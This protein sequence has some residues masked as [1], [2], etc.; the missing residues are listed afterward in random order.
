VENIALRTF[1][2][3]SRQFSN[4]N[5]FKRFINI[6]PKPKIFD[7]NELVIKLSIVG[8]V[9]VLIGTPNSFLLDSQSQESE[10]VKIFENVTFLIQK[11]DEFYD[12]D[13]YDE[14]I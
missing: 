2:S 7:L 1:R 3:T 4:T 9:L 8:F 10:N 13:Q 11:A 6:S 12:S 5:E 14:A